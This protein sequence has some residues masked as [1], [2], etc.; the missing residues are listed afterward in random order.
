MARQSERCRVWRY[1]PGSG[2]TQ[3]EDHAAAEEPLEVRVSGR[4]VS[5]TM[6]TP[7]HDDELAAGFVVGEGLV[8]SHAQIAHIRPCDVDAGAMVDVMLASDVQV[9]FQKLTRHVFASSSCGV[10]GSSTID[11]IRRQFP[12]LGEGPR[13]STGAI[14]GMPAALRAAQATFETTGGLHAAGLFDAAGNLL[15]AREDVGRHNAVDKVIGYALMRG[16]LPL[17]EHVLFVSGRVSFE[18][19]QKACSAG[20]C[21]VAAVSA[22]TSLAIELAEELG[23]TLAGFVRP[24]RFNVYSGW[25]RVRGEAG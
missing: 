16:M 17:G 7:G 1:E 22:P 4:A 21:V 11:A 19:V 9:D 12:P 14:L 15:V 24:P 20:L 6:R 25:E 3:A 2:L 18:I 13:V 23:M 10:C 8:T 5:V